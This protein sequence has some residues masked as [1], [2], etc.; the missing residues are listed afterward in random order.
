MD[1]I[2]RVIQIVEVDP[3][4]NVRQ[5]C[6]ILGIGKTTLYAHVGTLYPRPV[7]ISP[8]RVG[9]RA[10]EIKALTSA[11]SAPSAGSAA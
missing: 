11:P 7:R 4:L 3:L 8:K 5:V 2:S 6:S 9:W 1:K 10:S